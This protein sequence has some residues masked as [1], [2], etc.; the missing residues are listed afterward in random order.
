MTSTTLTPLDPALSPHRAV[1]ILSISAELLPAEIVASR[2]ARRSRGWVVIALVLVF[3]LLTVWYVAARID[4][5][6]A[7]RDLSVVTRQ[8]TTLQKK[9]TKSYREVVDVQNQTVTITKELKSLLADDLLWANLLDT[10]RDTGAGSGVTV[11]GINGSLDKAAG[12][13]TGATLPSTSK[14]SVVGTVTVTGSAPDKPTIAKYVDALNKLTTVANPYLTT[15]NKSADTNGD[16]VWQFNITIDVTSV[17]L[18]GRFT[19]K[20]T[21]S[22]R[23]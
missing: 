6:D 1:R 18:C 9:Q 12:T 23:K 3:A 21:P 16:S 5:N 14:A 11:A 7:N 10:L 19:I 15:A 4:V 17:A 13:D 2:R 8:A 22:G 20:C